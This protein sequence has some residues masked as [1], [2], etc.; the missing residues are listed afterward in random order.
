[1]RIAIFTNPNTYQ[2][3]PRPSTARCARLKTAIA[4]EVGNIQG[5]AERYIAESD[6]YVKQRVRAGTF[7]PGAG[8]D[9]IRVRY[10]TAPIPDSPYVDLLTSGHETTANRTRDCAGQYEDIDALTD[11]RGAFGCNLPGQS[12]RGGYDV[13]T[14]VLKGKAWETEPFCALDLLLK[15]HAEAYIAM[16]RGD[17]PRRAMEQFKFSLQRNVVALGRYNTSA[18]AGFVTAAGE[19][20]AVPEGTLDIGTVRRLAQIVKI[21]GW[22]GPFEVQ[23]STE[24][25]ERMRLKYKTNYNLELQSTIESNETHHLGDNTTVITWA[26]IR[27]VLT[28][29]P[30]RGY[31]KPT[32]SGGYEFVS[33]RPTKA[34]VG[35]GEGIVVDV[36]EDYFKG[37]TYCE[38]VKYPLY[39]AS[40][41]VHPNA[42]VREGFAMPRMAGKSW[43]GNLF[44]FEVNLIDGAYLDCN[45]DNFKGQFRIL[46]AYAFDSTNP[47]LMG[48]ILHAV[49]PEQIFVNEIIA[50]TDQVPDASIVPQEP[51]PLIGDDCTAAD[52]EA[53]DDAVSH[54]LPLQTEDDSNP[55]AVVGTLSFWSQGPLQTL[56]GNTLRVCVERKGGTSGAASVVLTPTEGTA[57]D[58]EDYETPGAATLEW[59]D[60]EAGRK[61]LDIPITEDASDGSAFTVAATDPTGAAWAGATSVT[62]NIEA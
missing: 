25:F 41:F 27:W 32:G 22:T 57:T 52:L 50:E 49:A 20:P 59:A 46:H 3:M 62:V 37:Y 16:L 56:P 1:L 24:A 31:L 51:G 58:P 35:T 17:L 42:A 54:L 7:D 5:M 23:I 61:C 8:E 11:A 48:A 45:K 55:D 21:Q 60:G 10:S 47:E 12:I 19:F 13:F 33:V 43:S 9:P 38:G 15:A 2:T 39:E 4:E 44:N 28:D 34:R 14:R 30:D 6:D 36:N 26:G 40:Y 18:T 29:T 53:C